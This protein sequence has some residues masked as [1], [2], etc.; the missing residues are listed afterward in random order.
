MQELWASERVLEQT[1]DTRR[2]LDV[3]SELFKQLQLRETGR[4]RLRIEISRN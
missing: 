1:D 4:Q 3:A 2:S